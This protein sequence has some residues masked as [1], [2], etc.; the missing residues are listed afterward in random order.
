MLIHILACEQ[1]VTKVVLQEHNN[2][3]PGRWI[4]KGVITFVTRGKDSYGITGENG[5]NYIRHRK[6]IHDDKADDI[7][8]SHKLAN[9]SLRGSA[10]LDEDQLG[11]I[12]D[13]FTLDTTLQ[14]E[15]A[16]PD[17]G[18]TDTVPAQPDQ[19]A[20]PTCTDMEQYTRPHTHSMG[21]V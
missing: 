10:S 18:D 19:P 13:F 7:S 12:P 20:Q 17:S 4:N 6:Y 8:I 5:K 3:K 14:Q 9:Y 21:P 1:W 15:A 16:A 2:F 11:P